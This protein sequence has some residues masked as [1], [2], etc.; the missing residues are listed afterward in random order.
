MLN[1]AFFVTQSHWHFLEQAFADP[2]LYYDCSRASSQDAGLVVTSLA[3]FYEV[4]VTYALRKQELERYAKDISESPTICPSGANYDAITGDVS[5]IRSVLARLETPPAPSDERIRVL[6][7]TSA[8][9]HGV[10]IDRLNAMIV[11]G[12]PKQTAEFIQATARVGRQ[13]PAV[14]FALVNP[15][16]VR[17]VNV[18][19]FPKVCGVFGSFIGTGSGES[20]I[21]SGV[22]A[23][24]PRWPDGA[25]A[26]SGRGSVALPEWLRPAQ[27]RRTRL[28]QVK[29]FLEALDANFPDGAGSCRPLARRR[30]VLTGQIPAS[31]N[32]Y[33]LQLNSYRA[34]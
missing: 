33:E 34:T 31:L 3:G 12:M 32:T 4:M 17:D 23:R 14:V 30:S 9:S 28:R 13:H 6:G 2:A 7:A 10:D 8:I 5:D 27:P 16:R 19:V 18:Q 22:E 20:R 24:S 15:M 25:V 11:L 29:G 1:A 21:S 26:P